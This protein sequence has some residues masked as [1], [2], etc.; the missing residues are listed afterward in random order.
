MKTYYIGADVDS[1]TTDLAI[2]SMNG[3]NKVNIAKLRVPTTIP[4]LRSALESIQGKK[5]LAI[6]ECTMSGWLYRNLREDVDEF[7]V[8]D[9]RKNALI[10]RDGDKNDPIDAV[11]L[12]ELLRGNYLREI[13]H[14]VDDNRICFKRWVSLYHDRVRD[15]VRQKNKL[16]A[17]GYSYGFRFPRKALKDYVYRRDWLISLDKQVGSQFDLL[18]IGY[19]SANRQRK[20][21]KEHLVLHSKEYEIINYWQSIPGISIIRSSTFF[22]WIDTPFR[23]KTAKKLWRYCGVGL[24]QSSSGKDREGN[25]KRGK[26]KLAWAVNRHLKNVLM[27]AAKSAVAC[28]DNVFKFYYERLLCK[29]VSSSNARHSVARKIAS[30]MWGMWKTSSRFDESLV[31]DETTPC[32]VFALRELRSLRELPIQRHCERSEAIWYS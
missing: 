21:A 18:L 6:E 11:K 13:Y 26:L 8:C 7:I 32:G 4:A 9:P 25:P 3:T 10:Y 30:V 29:G 12:A 19:D 15:V 20:I 31:I 23:F 14:S 5:K 24:I 27:G 22:V 28:G 17:L 16:R 2:T 1:K